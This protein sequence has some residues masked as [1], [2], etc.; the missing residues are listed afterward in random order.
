MV[1]VVAPIMQLRMQETDY[2][3]EL[4][5][6]IMTNDRGQRVYF[7]GSKKPK[8]NNYENLPLSWYR[9]ELDRRAKNRLIKK[10]EKE[11]KYNEKMKRWRDKYALYE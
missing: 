5:K 2:I 9:Y 3:G 10:I 1:L 6:D 7:W 8:D 11:E 4:K